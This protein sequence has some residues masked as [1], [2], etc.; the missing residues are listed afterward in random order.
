M[1]SAQDSVARSAE[2]AEVKKVQA[3]W[4]NKKPPEWVRIHA[5]PGFVRFPHMRHIKVLGTESCA[6]CHGDVRAMPQ[7]YQVATL[8]MGWCINCHVQRQVGRDC[9][10]CHY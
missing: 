7:V 9:T 8:K 10:L 5:L 2:I 6:T 4:I 1:T 3:A